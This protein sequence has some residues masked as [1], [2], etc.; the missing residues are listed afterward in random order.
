VLTWTAAIILLSTWAYLCLTDGT[1]APAGGG[2]NL[3]GLSFSYRCIN[4]GSGVSPVVPVLLLLASWYLW[5]LLQTWRLRFSDTARP[6]LPE[7]VDDVLD[8]RMFVS[9]EDLRAVGGPRDCG[10]Y[11]NLTCLLITRQMLCRFWKFP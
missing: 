10:L 11:K 7:R 6:W 2:V 5:A 1:D 8:G 3:V 4:P 9:D